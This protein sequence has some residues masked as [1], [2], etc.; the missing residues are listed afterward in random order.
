MKII[1]LVYVNAGGGHRS[2]ATALDM[3]IR[4]QGRDW[5]VRLVNLFEILDPQDV[6][7]RA[8]GVKPEDYYNVRL[9]RGWTLGLAQELRILQ[10][11]IRLTHKS[12]VSQLRRH[13]QESKPDLVV[14]LIP[15]F[16]RAMYQA[17]SLARPNVPYA[18][19]LTDLADFPPHFWIEPHQ[20][21]HLI[22][23]TPHAAAQARATAGKL[24]QVHETSGMIISPNFYRDMQL[25]RQAEMRKLQLDPQRPTGLVMFGGHGSRAMRGIAKRLDDVQLILV[26]GHNAELAAQLRAMRASAPRVVVGFTSKISHYMQLS[27]FFIGKP[28]PGSISEAVQ[29]GLPVIVVRNAWTMPQERYNTQWVVENGAGIVLDSF[30]SIDAGVAQVIGDLNLYRDSVKRIHNRAV[31]E[32]PEILDSILT[33]PPRVGVDLLQHFRAAERLHLS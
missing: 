28:G 3:A 33:A 13:W 30:K 27:D 24:A 9:A 6:F 23:G 16:N 20:A 19:V 5:Q 12:L 31:F 26:C 11:L 14:S 1:D 21:Q 2:A 8:T 18:T 25:D 29:Q 32:I 4:E 10:V 17:L 22:C 15:N 7:R